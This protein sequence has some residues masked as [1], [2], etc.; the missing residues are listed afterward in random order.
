MESRSRMP[1]AHLQTIDWVVIFCYLGGI[2]AL[3]ILVSRRVRNTS[4]F[5]LGNRSFGKVLMIAQTLGTGTH[6]DQAVGVAGAAYTIG[7]AGIWYQWMWLFTTPFYWLLAPIYR[8]LRVV[9]ISDFF[10]LR[11]GRLYATVYALFAIYLLALWQAIAIKGTTV[12]VSAITGITEWQIAVVVAAAF[13]AYGISGGLVAA[14]TT[15]FVQGFFIVFLSFLLLPFGMSKVGGFHGLHAQLPPGF[16]RVFSSSGG[17]LAPFTVTM[18][19]LS[20]LVGITVQPHMMAVASS[21]KTEWNCRVGWTFGN[22]VKRLCTIGWT[23]TGLL[24][25]V[26]FPGLGH[27]GRE[28]AFGIAV[29]YLLPAGLV[30]LMVASLLATVMA[31]CSAFMVDGAALFTRNVYQPYIAPNR[32]DSHYL[33]VG[34]YAS[35]AITLLGFV[36]GVTMPSVISATVHFVTIL[37]FVGVAFWMGIMWP[38]ANRYGAWVSSIGSAVLFGACL[39]GGVPTPWASLYSLIFG[40]ASIAVVSL[41]TPKEPQDRLDRVFRCLETPVGEE[42]RLA[43]LG[44][45]L[46]AQE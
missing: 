11:F 3:G 21:G 5:F 43:S 7:L 39:A 41:A 33:R 28:R 42:A 26:L 16:F 24:A 38:R 18:L 22:F 29:I 13:A 12:T 14:A 30:G 20:G 46:E 9:T 44:L 15:D 6:S 34:R 8:R 10:E 1:T 4:A 31:T 45:A 35:F 25:A 23:L 2:T 19:V 17:E 37:P 27:A 32:Q 40:F 36:L